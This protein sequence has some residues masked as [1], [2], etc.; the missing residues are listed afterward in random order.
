[1][2]TVKINAEFDEKAFPGTRDLEDALMGIG[3]ED[4]TINWVNEPMPVGE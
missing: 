3:A 4:I 2:I 1:M